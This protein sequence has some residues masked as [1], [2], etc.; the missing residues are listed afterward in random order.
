MAKIFLVRH[1][2]ASLGVANYDELSALGAEQARLLGAWWARSGQRFDIVATG[3]LRR[4]RQTAEECLPALAVGRAQGTLVLPDGGFDEYDQHDILGAVVPAFR[5]PEELNAVLATDPDGPRR[6]FQ[7]IF[8]AAFERWVAGR[9]DGDYAESW[10]AF[11]ARCVD[12]ILALAAQCA[13]GTSAIVF[14]SGGPIAAICQHLLGIPDDRIADLHFS[15]RNASVTKLLFQPG[16]LSLS[17]FNSVAHLDIT[18]RS[19]VITYR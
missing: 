11:R 4:H 1:G 13:S 2:Q 18:G 3:R 10:T 9:H 12:A 15:L 14:T 17:Y 8:S 19:N 7:R 16:R 5:R 6:A